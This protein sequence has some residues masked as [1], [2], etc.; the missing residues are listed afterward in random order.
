MW[1]DMEYWK[2]KKKIREV[3]IKNIAKKERVKTK[4]EDWAMI[5]GQK[6]RKLILRVLGFDTKYNLMKNKLARNINKK[7]WIDTGLDKE[8]TNIE[9]KDKNNSTS[10][11]MS[12][13]TDEPTQ[14]AEMDEIY[15]QLQAEQEEIEDAKP[16]LFRDINY[17]GL[18]KEMRNR[19]KRENTKTYRVGL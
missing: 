18:I 7:E 8:I 5:L 6:T 13:N 17:D 9:V 11:L 2:L 10:L 3:I 19:E 12:I 1:I 16:E 15:A 4:N 14:N